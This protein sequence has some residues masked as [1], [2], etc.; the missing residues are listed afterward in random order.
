MGSREQ[1][2]PL[3]RTMKHAAAALREAD[4]EFMLGGGL[5]VWARGGPPTDHDVDFYVREEHAARGMEALVEAGLRPERPPEEW[6]YKAYEGDVLVDLIFRP[7]GGPLGDEHFARATWLEVSAQNL[8]V[9]SVDDVLVMKLLALT[10]Q[11]PDF[12]HVL[13]IARA[14]REQ[15]DWSFVRDRAG[16]SPFGQAFL[17][18]AEGL[19]IVEGEDSLAA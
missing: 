15:I 19:G 16:I 7:A 14:L 13:Q 5:A 12:R 3:V 9:A 10:E 1:V 8:L 2:E 17:T 6:L 11:E 18:L 4:L